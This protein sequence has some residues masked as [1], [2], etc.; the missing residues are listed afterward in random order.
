MNS[1]PKIRRSGG[2][3]IVL[4][5]M[6]ILV[7]VTGL[8]GT[9]FR[10][11]TTNLRATTNL[12][13]WDLAVAAAQEKIETS[14]AGGAFALDPG[15]AEI[16]DQ[17]IDVDLDG[18]NDFLLDFAAPVCVRATQGAAT[19][20]SSVS[21]PGIAAAG[22]WNTVWELEAV[23]TDLATG[24]SVTLTNGVRVL[25]NDAERNSSCP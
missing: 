8:V 5:A 25:L 17:P 6:L 14:I 16:S 12:Q 11:S 19:T 21:L 7:L 3:I 4:M 9:A 22:S 24:A 2:A 1:L 10:M 18:R 23:A 20:V 15:S 13:S